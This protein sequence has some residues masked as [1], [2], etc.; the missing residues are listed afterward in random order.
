ML[1]IKKFLPPV[2]LAVLLFLLCSQF[3]YYSD[4]WFWGTDG[5]L[6]TFF[7][8]FSNPDNPFHFYNNGR[9]LGNGLGF[10]AANHRLFR[11]LVMTAVLL[12]IITCITKISLLT[13]GTASASLKNLMLAVSASLLLLCPKEMFRESIGWS[14]AFMI[15]VVP[16]ALYLIGIRKI[17]SQDDA[18][19]TDLLFFF[20]PLISAFFVEN[21]TIGNLIFIILWILYRFLRKRKPTAGEW[22]YFAGSLTGLVLMFADDGYHQ[23]LQGNPEDTYWRAETASLG[24]MI[25]KAV[26]SFRGFI[27]GAV[28]GR[29]TLVTLFAALNCSAACLL[30]RN[31][32]AKKK[33]IWLILLTLAQLMTAVYFLMQ[34]LLPAPEIFFG[35]TKPVEAVFVLL[36]LFSLPCMVLLLPVSG[37]QKEQLV[38]T[39]IFAAA[40]TLPLTVAEP[41]SMRVFFPTFIFLLLLY[42]QI[43]CLNLKEIMERFSPG[44]ARIFIPYA[45]GIFLAVWGYLFC[46]YAAIAHYERERIK[47]VQYRESLGEYQIN[48]PTL[49]YADHVIVSYPWGDT[50]QERYKKF[51][52]LNVELKLDIVSFEEWRE[53]ISEGF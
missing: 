49:P 17:F 29:M 18:G 46:I 4:D 1:R 7:D 50:W 22:L 44:A 28:L 5:S 27:A 47:Y 33:R 34:Q 40:A 43:A 6:S 51:F 24:S 42:C 25:I 12:G 35:A 10:L 30:L 36:F 16:S 2:L 3:S 15:Y 52:G 20:L 48:F 32:T 19:K 26:T 31:R 38:F 9:Y 11:N 39:W 21:L 14:V 45:A 37:R 23:I 53:Q 13:A 8:S 41:L